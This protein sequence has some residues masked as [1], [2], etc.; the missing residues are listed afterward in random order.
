MSE[1]ALRGRTWDA[2]VLTVL[3]YSPS[4]IRVELGG[5]GLDGF[6]SLGE[7]DEACVFEFPTPEAARGLVSRPGRW[8]SLHEIKPNWIAIGI[9]VHPG[10]LASDW[11]GQAKVGD[12]LRITRHKTWFRRPDEAAWQIL[13][14]DITALPA[15]ARIVTESAQLV[16]T[17]AVI[18]IPDAGDQQ[19]WPAAAEADIEWVHN[20]ELGSKRSRLSELVSKLELPPGEGYIYVAGEVAETR[21]ARKFLSRDLKLGNDSF[22]AVGYWRRGT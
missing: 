11:A 20:P 19:N 15:I 9:V 10:G 4:L 7:P 3:Q 14:G 22:G 16:P 17:R 1:A 8:Y 5:A 6:V 2:E 13:L 12:T 18:E 21:A